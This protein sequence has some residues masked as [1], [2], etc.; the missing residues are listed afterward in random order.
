[1]DDVRGYLHV[2]VRT[3][4][5]TSMD[6]CSCLYTGTDPPADTEKLKALRWLMLQRKSVRTDIPPE[7]EKGV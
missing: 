7:T 4:L 2:I 3:Y 5:Y 1:M 6:N